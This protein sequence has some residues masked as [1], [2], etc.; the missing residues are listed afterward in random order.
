MSDMPERGIPRSKLSTR[1]LSEEERRLLLE[2][3][4]KEL[5]K[6]KRREKR[7]SRGNTRKRFPVALALLIVFFLCLISSLVTLFQAGGN[8]NYLTATINASN[9]DELD[10]LALSKGTITEPSIAASSAYLMDMETGD[11]LYEKD[12]DRALPMASTTKIMTALVV[13]E[14]ADLNDSVTISESASKVGE[15]SAWLVQGEALTVEQLLYALLVQSGNDAAV[16]LAEYIGGTQ[17]SFVKMMNEKAR[18]LGAD[19]THFANPHGLDQEGH[20]SSARDLAVIAATAMKNPLFRKIVKSNGYQI[21]WPGHPY[22][23]VLENHNKLLKMYPYATG[24]KTGYTLNAGKCLVASAEKNG[25]ELISVILNGGESYWDQTI[26]LMEYGFDAFGVVEF[27]YSGQSMAS[28][29]VG[30]FPRRQVNA[31]PTSNLAFTVRRELLKDFKTATLYYREWVPYPVAC[32]QE[33]GYVV[34]AEGSEYEQRGELVSDSQCKAP[35]FPAR[36]YAFVL[37]ALASLWKAVKWII[38]GL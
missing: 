32:G 17:E 37:A 31:V 7:R 28:V 13:M 16:A 38:P 8:T 27:A 22:P 21:P 30:R 19:N 26:R 3:R 20:Y 2:K 35:S 33:V 36:F 11:T 10:D 4:I 24:I 23:R 29:S 5:R 25:R 15:S 1:A 9:Q 12:A 18:E 14:K 6:R 34:A